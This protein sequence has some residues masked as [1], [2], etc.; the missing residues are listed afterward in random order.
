MNTISGLAWANVKKDR[1]RSILI[2]I[3]ILLTTLLLT[4]VSGVGYG[5]IR[6]NKSNA[7]D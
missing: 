4:A 7:A 5:M 1:V 2:A 6:M 3:S